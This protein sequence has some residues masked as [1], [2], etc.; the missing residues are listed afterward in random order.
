MKAENI[1]FTENTNNILFQPSRD[2]I[3]T[4]ISTGVDQS[5][6]DKSTAYDHNVDETTLQAN[7]IRCC[8]CGVL[9]VPNECNTCLQCLKAQVDITEGITKA[10]QL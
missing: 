8:L 6:A 1:N 9:M 3:T 7:M 4:D 10:V 2:D 5:N